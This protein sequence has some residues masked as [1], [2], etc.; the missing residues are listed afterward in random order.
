MT[1]YE[2]ALCNKNVYTNHCQFGKQL[3]RDK[4]L[5]KKFIKWGSSR[6]AKGGRL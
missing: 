4:K 2:V 3:L 5:I 6:E 1:K